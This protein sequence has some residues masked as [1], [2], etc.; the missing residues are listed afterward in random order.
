MSTKMYVGSQVRDVVEKYEV[1]DRNIKKETAKD[2]IKP[3]QKVWTRL[4]N[5]LFSK[6]IQLK[7]G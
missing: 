6:Q 7:V 1:M 4:D 5:G 2:A 3:K